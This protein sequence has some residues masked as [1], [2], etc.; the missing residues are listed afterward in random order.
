ML[1]VINFVI[2]KIMPI[3]IKLRLRNKKMTLPK[4]IFCKSLESSDFFLIPKKELIILL[5]HINK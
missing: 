2:I 4:D 1:E 3:N 5:N